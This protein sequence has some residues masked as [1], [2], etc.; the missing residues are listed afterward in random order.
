MLG[1]PRTTQREEPKPSGFEKRLVARIIERGVPG[2]IRSDNGPEFTAIAVREW[3]ARLDVKTL[4]IEPGSP[5]ENGFNESFN[6]K[7]RDELLDREIFYTLEEARVLI[8]WWR[9]EY[10]HFRSAQLTGLCVPT[11]STTREPCR[12]A[13]KSPNPLGVVRI[14]PSSSFS[15]VFS[16]TTQYAEYLSPRSTPIVSVIRFAMP[17]S[18]GP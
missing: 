1:Q 12:S 15:P 18:L 4:F 6:G 9:D 14:R 7:L 8:G 2:H 11:S 16:S 3:L 10:N 5:W 17:I 13:K